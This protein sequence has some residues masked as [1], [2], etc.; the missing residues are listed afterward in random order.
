[1]PQNEC[2]GTS[3]TLT[4]NEDMVLLGTQY[5]QKVCKK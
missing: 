3:V 5:A 2:S 1:M 4:L